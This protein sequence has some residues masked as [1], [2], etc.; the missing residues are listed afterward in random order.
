M[1]VDQ[2]PSP[3][4]PVATGAPAPPGDA[5]HASP[6][7]LR[8]LAGRL[9]TA[10]SFARLYLVIIGVQG[11]HVIE[12]VIQLLQVYAF[13]VAD[14]DALGLLGYVFQFNG[15][16]EWLHLAFNAA[17]VAS[18]YVVLIGLFGLWRMGALPGWSL[19]LYAGYAVGLESWHMVEHIVIIGNVLRNGGC[20]CPG[21]GD[22]ALQVSDTQL[23]FVYN[24]LAY[25]GT[26]LPAR[27]ILSRRGP[28]RR[29]RHVRSPLSA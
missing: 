27:A 5:Q 8:S 12:H 15:T 2:H 1:T 13:G 10:P 16:E 28:P 14:D 11:V 22:R 25:A 18:L 20:P 24:L 3:P 4:V 26:L 23:H 29:R 21:I 7:V 17:Y 6:T 9:A 19:G